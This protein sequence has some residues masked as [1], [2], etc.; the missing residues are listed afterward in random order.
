MRG[1]SKSTNRQS[2]LTN[3]YGINN[4]VVL[5]RRTID[6]FIIEG[7]NLINSNKLYN[8]YIRLKFGTNKKYRT[9]VLNMMYFCFLIIFVFLHLQDNQINYKSKMASIIYI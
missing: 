7:R 3:R 1:L 9:Q 2:S 4:N 8:P 6:V 5:T